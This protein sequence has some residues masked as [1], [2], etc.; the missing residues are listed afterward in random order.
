MG[1]REMWRF[2]WDILVILSVAVWVLSLAHQGYI[3]PWLAALAL[4]I[5]VRARSAAR[6]RGGN[7]SRFIRMLF[8]TLVPIASLAVFVLTYSNGNPTVIS[9]IL[10][11]LLELGIVLAGLYVMI[12]HLFR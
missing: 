4:V 11:L 1:D 2:I 7:F 8:T 10:F 9:Q 5:F 6:S 12:Y 3:P